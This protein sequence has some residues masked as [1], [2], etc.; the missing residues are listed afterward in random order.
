VA[1]GSRHPQDSRQDNFRTAGQAGWAAVYSFN[2]NKI[3]TTSG[4]GML[5][6]RDGGVVA[7]ARKRAQQAREPVAWYEHA[8]LG[9]NYRM[10]NIVAAIGVGQLACLERIILK[11]RQIFE[12]YRQRLGARVSFMPEAAYGRCTRWLTVVEFSSKVLKCGSSEGE[13]SEVGGRRSAMV[14]PSE[15]VERVR[16]ALEA[17]DIESRPVWKP[18]HLQ[19]VFRGAKVYGGS[20]S[21]RLFGCGLCLPSG[22]GL[23]EADV[24]RVCEVV[25]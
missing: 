25:L 2:G 21:E 17:E 22:S 13:R 9:Y 16:L 7:R 19:P 23:E 1:V 8:E 10:S 15:N 20:L 11:K 18:M 24:D 14:E 5:A 4:G 3:I 12:W 6:S